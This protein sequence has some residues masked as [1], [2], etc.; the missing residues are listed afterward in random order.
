MNL[1]KT[2][3]IGSSVS[4]FPILYIGTAYSKLKCNESKIPFTTIAIFLPFFYGLTYTI[5]QTSLKNIIP[6]SFKRQIIIGIIAGEIYSLFG[7]FGA[8]IPETVFKSSNPNSVH[9]IAPIMY[10]IIY[11]TYAYYLEKYI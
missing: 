9:I 3:L 4:I 2:F 1:L 10:A 8:R 11:S 6:D 7:H 5:L